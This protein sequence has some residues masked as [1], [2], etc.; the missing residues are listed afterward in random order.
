MADSKF[1]IKQDDTRP[2]LRVNITDQD[3]NV[4]DLTGGSVKFNMVSDD[5]DRTVKV[6]SSADI[7]TATS[8]VAEY[9]WSSSDTDTAGKYLGEFQVTLSDGTV[10]SVPADD[11]LKVIIKKDYGD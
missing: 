1:N 3:G 4:V 6:N 8:G 10:F 7:V 2:Y 11:S 5:N 9:R